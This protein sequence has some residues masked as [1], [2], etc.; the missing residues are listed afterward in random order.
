MP[1]AT[2]AGT[3]VSVNDE[4]FFE[5]AFGGEFEIHFLAEF[6]VEIA[7]VGVDEIDSGVE[8]DG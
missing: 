6:P 8:A 1:T 3:T 4:G 2:Y 7:F 5:D